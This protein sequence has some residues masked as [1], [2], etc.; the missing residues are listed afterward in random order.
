MAMSLLVGLGN[1]GVQYE[2]TRH[3]AGFCLVEQFATKYGA[4]FSMHK[5]MQ[6]ELCKVRINGVDLMLAKPMTYMNLSGKAV[7]AVMNFYKIDKA[8]LIVAHDEVAL[9]LGKIRLA[10]G[11]GSA[12]N[13]GIES[14]FECLGYKEFQRLRIGVGPDP[15]GAVRAHFV[16][17]KMT[18]RDHE[19]LGRVVEMAVEA[20]EVC[21]KDGIQTAMNKF[22]GID[23]NEKD[24][25]KIIQSE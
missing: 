18:E 5:N 3:N 12:G 19:L 4:S 10:R 21:L 9:P 15:G 23:L 20:T 22:N 1:P 16:L 11:G 7:A 13:H 17:S 6:A 24:D 25:A 8:N 2:N 14:I